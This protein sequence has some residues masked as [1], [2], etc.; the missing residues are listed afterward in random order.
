MNEQSN[1][2]TQISIDFKKFRIRVHDGL[3]S[4]VRHFV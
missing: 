3:S 2:F 1:L 4:Q